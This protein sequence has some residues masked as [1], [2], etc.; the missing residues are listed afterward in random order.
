MREPENLNGGEERVCMCR[1]LGVARMSERKL[2]SSIR[3]DKREAKIFV[4]LLVGGGRAREKYRERR[5]GGGRASF[6]FFLLCFYDLLFSLPGDAGW[7]RN[8]G[9]R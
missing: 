3:C 4:L 6:L 5:R 1:R 9:R 2:S 7:L 8:E